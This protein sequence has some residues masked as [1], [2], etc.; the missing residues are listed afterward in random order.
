MGYIDTDGTNLTKAELLALTTVVET[1]ERRVFTKDVQQAYS[2][3]GQKGES[4]RRTAF[5]KNQSITTSEIN[6]LFAAPV[7]D[8]VSPANGV[9]AGGTKV[10]IKGSNLSGN[11]SVTFGGTAATSVVVVNQNTITCTAPAHAAGTVDV[12]VT[13]DAGSATKTGG[14]V[15][16]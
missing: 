6:A 5:V 9:V 8:T 1:V 2:Y 4:G 13:D 14:F 12:V 7:V 3:E 10:T 15:Y 16:A 11:Q